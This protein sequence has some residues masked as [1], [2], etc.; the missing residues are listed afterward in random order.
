MRSDNLRR[1]IQ[2]C[3]GDSTSNNSPLEHNHNER[4]RSEKIH[5]LFRKLETVGSSTS[6]LDKHPVVEE[7]QRPHSPPL[8][9][10]KEEN[11]DDK[12]NNT[13]PSWE[14]ENKRSSL[15]DD[16]GT[17][18]SMEKEDDRSSLNDMMEIDEDSDVSSAED[19]V[20]IEMGD[21]VW[22]VICAGVTIMIA[23]YS[24]LLNTFF[25]C[26]EL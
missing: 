15:G 16:D 11:S 19:E 8:P 20:D 9:T 10:Y 6:P 18:N 21:K 22:R 25:N 13:I 4:E 23:I 26:V 2:S 14:E 3:M 5:D 12:D 24:I 7:K 17:S 1:H